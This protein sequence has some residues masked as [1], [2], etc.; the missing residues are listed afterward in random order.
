MKLHRINKVALQ[1]TKLWDEKISVRFW[2][3]KFKYTQ[4]YVVID[5]IR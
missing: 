1:R 3:R 4:K 2:Q 5:F